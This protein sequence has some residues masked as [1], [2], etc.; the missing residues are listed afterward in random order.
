MCKKCGKKGCGCN[1]KQPKRFDDIPDLTRSTQFYSQ[2]YDIA[3]PSGNWKFDLGAVNDFVGLKVNNVDLG[4]IPMLTGNVSNLNEYVTDSAG[5]QWI[6][7]VL[8]NAKKLAGGGGAPVNIIAGTGINVTGSY[9]NITISNAYADPTGKYVALT[10]ADAAYNVNQTGVDLN[11]I[12]KTSALGIGSGY[13]NT[14]VADQGY[15][16]TLGKGPGYDFKIFTAE[17]SVDSSWYRLSVG[18]PGS[19][20]QFASRQWVTAQ[21]YAIGDFVALNTTD[22]QYSSTQTS[23]NLNTVSTTS[24]IGIGSGYSN[25]PVSDTGYLLT[26]G[27]GAAYDFKIFSAENTHDSAWYRLSIGIPGSWYQIA[28]RSWVTA[29]GY[30]TNTGTVT[31][32]SAQDLNAGTYDLFSVNVTNPT[33]IPDLTFSLPTLPQKLV[34]AAPWGASG[35]PFWRQL[36]TSDLQQNGATLG[37]V[38]MWDGTQWDKATLTYPAQ[39]WQR[40]GTVLSPTTTGDTVNITKNTAGMQTLLT[41]ENNTGNGVNIN[42]TASG[43]T[44]GYLRNSYDGTAWT[45]DMYGY[46]RIM[47]RTGVSPTQVATIDS[48]GN[49]LVG[50]G[51][52][53]AGGIHLYR[54]T[55]GADFRVHEG[56]PSGASTS[57]FRFISSGTG[58]SHW[59]FQ[60]GNNA[61]TMNGRFRLVDDAVGTTLERLTILLTNGR[62]GINKVAPTSQLHIGGD[63]A[64][65]S[66]PTSSTSVNILTSS[67][68]G[69]GTIQS[70]TIA[71]LG[72]VANGDVWFDQTTGVAATS[73]GQ[74]IA[75]AG[76]VRIGA[77]GSSAYTLSLIGNAGV[78]SDL[79]FTALSVGLRGLDSGGAVRYMVRQIAGSFVE[80]GNT[81][82]DLTLP[83]YLNTRD[84]TPITPALNALFTSSAGG[85]RSMPIRIIQNDGGEVYITTSEPRTAGAGNSRV[86]FNT[87][88]SST[89][90]LFSYD[91]TTGDVKI[92]FGIA[93]REVIAFYEI[94]Y[95]TAGTPLVTC[96]L[97]LNNGGT[98]FETAQSTGVIGTNRIKGAE[99]ISGVNATDYASINVGCTGSN[100]TITKAKIILTPRG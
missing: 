29:Q 54:T 1:F 78:S 57:L 74:H 51:I 85:L 26:M 32:F 80:I 31:N 68:S 8:G 38:I 70:R 65:D 41:L 84:D 5:D 55:G 28:S 52:T 6:I 73:N 87:N 62:T 95:T 10:D 15:L 97:R 92:Q 86:T 83:K 98:L 14:P 18:I 75:R 46:G 45:T 50:T 35:T 36:Q 81:T 67:G 59:L 69:S 76:R 43:S 21:N 47:F 77:T 9:P 27:R 34:F 19:W 40:S 20:Y 72:I 13:S 71:S 61:S 7:D 2:V 42:L 82:N 58:G 88:R 12:H 49:L 25:T 39:Y 89:N 24:I 64:I 79:D 23:V 63:L 48:S 30:T 4:Y 53:A 100:I 22:A 3:E 96:E 93:G 37:Q 33:T 17:N 94:E 11:T 60:T 99:L 56:S 44:F 90:S 66:I 91:V 16:L